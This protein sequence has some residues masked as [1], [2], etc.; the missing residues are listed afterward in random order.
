MDNKTFDDA[1]AALNEHQRAPILRQFKDA[2]LNRLVIGDEVHVYQ[3]RTLLEA[4]AKIEKV[5][6]RLVVVNGVRYRRQKRG[7]SFRTEAL[8]EIC[9]SRRIVL[10]DEVERKELRD[11]IYTALRDGYPTLD[12]LRQALGVLP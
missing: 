2:L 8:T 6:R 7:N 9:G 11:E 1:W 5:T 3:G 10:S 12:Q 4:R